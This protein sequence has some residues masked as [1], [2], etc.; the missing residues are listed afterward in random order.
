MKILGGKTYFWEG[1]EN[2]WKMKNYLAAFTIRIF[3]VWFDLF[4]KLSCLGY[5]GIWTF[6]KKQAINCCCCFLTVPHVSRTLVPQ[7]GMNLCPLSMDAQSLTTESAG[8]S[9][10]LKIIITLNFLR[11]DEGKF[12]NIEKQNQN[13]FSLLYI[14]LPEEFT[15]WFQQ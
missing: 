11:Q 4:I 5:W 2:W 12:L 6:R 1:N 8:K 9:P 13:P 10:F 15:L 7:P 3:Y 14:D